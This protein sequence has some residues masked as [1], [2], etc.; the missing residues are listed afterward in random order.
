M[1]PTLRRS[2]NRLWVTS[3]LSHRQ[4]VL[5]ASRK[6]EW[7]YAWLAYLCW[8]NLSHLDKNHIPRARAQHGSSRSPVQLCAG[9][10]VLQVGALQAGPS[11]LTQDESSSIPPLMRLT[12]SPGTAGSWDTAH[13]EHQGSLQLP[14]TPSTSFLRGKSCCKAFYLGFLPVYFCG[15][16]VVNIVVNT[17]L[18]LPNLYSGNKSH[19]A[20]EKKKLPESNKWKTILSEIFPRNSQSEEETMHGALN[21]GLL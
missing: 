14:V 7:G 19:T 5:A 3:A 9:G 21:K 17:R 12:H 8:I 15:I 13:S 6:C 11:L 10:S 1:E 18:E 16:V 2:V 4:H 20:F